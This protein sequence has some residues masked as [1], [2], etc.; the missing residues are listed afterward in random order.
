MDK[1]VKTPWPDDSH[2]KTLREL[3]AQRATEADPVKLQELDEQI[4]AITVLSRLA[5]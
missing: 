1:R 5:R 2:E 4:E 3:V